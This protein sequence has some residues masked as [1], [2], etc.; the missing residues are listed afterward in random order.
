MRPATCLTLLLV[1]P[2]A[3]AQGA[4]A[5]PSTDVN[6]AAAAFQ[7]GQRLQLARE[8]ARAAEFFE[9]ADQA[10]PSPAALRSAIRSRQAAGQATRAATLSL[11]AR[12]R[13]AADPQ[14]AQL[15]AAVLAEAAARLTRVHVT[16]SPACAVTVD[17]L[18][19]DGA[20]AE[21]HTFFVEPGARALETRWAGRGARARALDCAAGQSVELSLDAPPPEAPTVTPPTPVVTPP[22]PIIVVAP[23]PPPPAA[24]RAR[25]PLP[26]VVFWIGLGATVASGAALTWSGVDTLSARDAYLQQPTEAGFNDG[27]SREVR[28]DALVAATA[29]LGL[30]TAVVGAFLTEWSGGSSERAGLRA[31]PSVALGDGRAQVTVIGSF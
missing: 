29:T 27:V 17:R 12:D 14:S 5:A 31:V 1:T 18:A 21:S 16:C 28:T 3:A 13:D 4:P 2:L 30:A 11:R 15:A 20:A 7:E 9:I 26:P 6:A 24:P 10:A 8:Y 23:P 22:A 25:R 19:I